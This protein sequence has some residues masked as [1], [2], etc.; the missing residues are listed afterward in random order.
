[1]AICA[2]TLLHV[3]LPTIILKDMVFKN[4]DVVVIRRPMFFPIDMSCLSLWCTAYGQCNNI[5]CLQLPGV[6]DD[7]FSYE[8]PLGAVYSKEAVSLYLW[9]PTAQV[10][11]FPT[12]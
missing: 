8:G 12:F 7:L 11:Q 9:A 2:V 5:T 6:L 3:F 10:Y 4:M 1:M